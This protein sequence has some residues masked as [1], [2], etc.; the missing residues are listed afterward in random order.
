LNRRKIMNE[1]IVNK[2][3]GAAGTGTPPRVAPQALM[4]RTAAAAPL[5]LKASSAPENPKR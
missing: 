4:Q 2:Y 1:H 3:F 5:S